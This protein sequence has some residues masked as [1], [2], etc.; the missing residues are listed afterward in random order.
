MEG[1]TA[2][3]ALGIMLGA[4]STRSQS[5]YTWIKPSTLLELG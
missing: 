4:I 3:Q 2:A 1:H 5:I